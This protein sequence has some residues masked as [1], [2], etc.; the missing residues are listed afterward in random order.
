M[1]HPYK[2][3]TCPGVYSFE[4]ITSPPHPDYVNQLVLTFMVEIHNNNI[5]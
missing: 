3:V 2:S 4:K 1:S 5:C